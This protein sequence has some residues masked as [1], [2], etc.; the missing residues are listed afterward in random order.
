MSVGDFILERALKEAKKKSAN[1]KVVY[2]L[3]ERSANKGNAE[4]LYAIGTWH[5]HGKY[6]RK[7]ASIAVKYFLKSIEKN[8][9]SASYDLAVCYEKGLALK[10]IKRKHLKIT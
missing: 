10:K 5:L 8:H 3:L 2:Q 7:D 6:V 1:L 9:S 4:A